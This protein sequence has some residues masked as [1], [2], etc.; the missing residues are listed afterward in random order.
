MRRPP[1]GGGRMMD[2]LDRQPSRRTSRKALADEQLQYAH[3]GDG[4]GFI[5]KRAK[6]RDGAAGV[7]G[8]ARPGARHQEPHAGPSRPLSRALR[9]EGDRQ[10]AA[11]CT[12]PRRRRR[13]APSSSTICRE[14][15]REDRHQGQVDDLRGDRAQPS[16]RG[17]TA[18]T[19]VETDLGEYIIQLRDEP[20]SHIIA[21]AVHLTR[22]QVEAD[23]RRPTPISTP[24]AT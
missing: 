1:I 22:D 15:R 13:R 14:R 2:M 9:G 18:S 21:P 8:A 19:P 6:A 17:A 12:G 16:P 20:P 11:M 24:T 10:P 23:F 7:R 4:P 5:D 3:D